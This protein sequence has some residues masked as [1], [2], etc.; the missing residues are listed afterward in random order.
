MEWDE[1]S[2]AKL[3]A[4]R[5]D[6]IQLFLLAKHQLFTEKYNMVSCSL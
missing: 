4:R 5:L 1:H 3:A 2:V 6:Q